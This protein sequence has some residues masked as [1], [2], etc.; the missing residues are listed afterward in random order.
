MVADSSNDTDG[1]Y[2]GYQRG[3]FQPPKSAASGENGNADFDTP[4][5]QTE[6]TLTDLPAVHSVE[7]Y[8]SQHQLYTVVKMT[9]DPNGWWDSAEVNFYLAPD[10]DNPVKIGRASGG[11]SFNGAL[12]A[13]IEKATTDFPW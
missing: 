4:P 8:A 6:A 13:A 11:G 2:P 5:K 12:S 1:R 9:F 10:Y 3:G 7:A